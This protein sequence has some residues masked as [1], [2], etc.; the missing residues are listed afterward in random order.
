MQQSNTRRIC[1]SCM[2]DADSVLPATPEMLDRLRKVPMMDA[3]ITEKLAQKAAGKVAD[4]NNPAGLVNGTIDTNL[5]LFRAYLKMWLDANPDIAHDSDCFVSTLP[6][7][8]T[9]IPL[10]VYCFTAT[11]AWFAYEGIQD[12]IFEHVAAM[13]RFFQ[14]YT[15]E[16]PSGRDTIIDG[17]LSPGGKIDELYGIPYPFFQSSDAP[18]APASTRPVAP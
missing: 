10:Q 5:G 15:F 17:Y 6:Q 9:G 16:N 11:S 8:A 18:D 7:T 12:A 14:L 2:I 3:Y 4:V 13:L 1:R